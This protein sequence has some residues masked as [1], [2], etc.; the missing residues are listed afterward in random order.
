MQKLLTFFTAQ[1]IT[2]MPLVALA[3]SG[4]S[5]ARATGGGTLGPISNLFQSFINFINDILIPL[6]FALAIL[7]F[8]WGIFYYFILGGGDDGKREQGRQLMLWAII[9]FVVMASIYGIVAIISQGLG[10]AG[11]NNINV[12]TVPRRG[13]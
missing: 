8:F 12:P 2:L 4:A 6:V 10:I 13:Q 11:V 7:V 9:G 1:V 3:Q 5:G